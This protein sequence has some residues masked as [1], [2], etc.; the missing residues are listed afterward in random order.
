MNYLLGN[1]H[2][3]IYVNSVGNELPIEFLMYKKINY[4]CC[5]CDKIEI[6]N[7]V[8]SCVNVY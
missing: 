8:P 6:N 4:L 1:R 7:L 2:R 3:N 5:K